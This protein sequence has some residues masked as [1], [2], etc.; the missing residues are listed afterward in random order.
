[1]TLDHALHRVDGWAGRR[2]ILPHKGILAH[3][4][5]TQNRTIYKISACKQMP[6]YQ[7]KKTQIVRAEPARPPRRPPNPPR[8]MPQRMACPPS[9]PALLSPSQADS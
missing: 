2:K 9:S 6:K 3:M 8:P 4:G 1:M 7:H 5:R